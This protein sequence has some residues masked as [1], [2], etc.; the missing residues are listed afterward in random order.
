MADKPPSVLDDTE[1][2]VHARRTAAR[3]T[4]SRRA[5]LAVGGLAAAATIAF[6]VLPAS[7]FLPLATQTF[8]TTKDEH[9]SIKL[10]D[11]STL[12]LNAD[13][14]LSVTLGARDRR[15]VM[16]EG[17]AVFDVAPDKA[18]PFLIAVGDRILRVVGTRFD[19]RRRAGQLSVTIE[20]G[21]VEVG[22][23]D[24]PAGRTFRLG[25]GQRLDHAEGGADVVANLE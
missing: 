9:R 11:G 12:D 22:P 15:V 14:R 23:A 1:R 8:A 2:D 6:A 16:A 20:R 3:S 5:W 13:S 10:A 25:H 4:G 18:R 7:V 17:D 19:V 21:L 24:S